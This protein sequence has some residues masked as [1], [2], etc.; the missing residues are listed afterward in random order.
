MPQGSLGWR[1][2]SLLYG[3]SCLLLVGVIFYSRRKAVGGTELAL[4][5]LAAGG[6]LA[7]VTVS[8]VNLLGLANTNGDSPVALIAI[9]TAAF[10]VGVRRRAIGGLEFSLYWFGSALMDHLV[11]RRPARG[12]GDRQLFQRYYPR[13]PVGRNRA[14]EHRH[15]LCRDHHACPQSQAERAGGDRLSAWRSL[16]GL[17]GLPSGFAFYV[18]RSPDWKTQSTSP[19][20]LRRLIKVSPAKGNAMG[21]SSP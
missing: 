12:I 7:A 19:L 2:Y 1:M 3:V 16:H 13:L 20:P 18:F 14:F 9:L 11:P 4:Y 21:R 10:L 15:R 8:A 17:G 6:S 5:W